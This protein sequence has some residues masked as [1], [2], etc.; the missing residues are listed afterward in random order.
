MDNFRDMA[1]VIYNIQFWQDRA[2]EERENRENEL[3]EL[4]RQERYAE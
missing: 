1:V 3:R 2:L 4:R